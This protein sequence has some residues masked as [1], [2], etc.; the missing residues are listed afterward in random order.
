MEEL[1]GRRRELEG[2]PEHPHRA[3]SDSEIAHNARIIGIIDRG[4]QKR[5]GDWIT[6]LAR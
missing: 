2:D 4:H 3:L 1:A 5:G 6:F